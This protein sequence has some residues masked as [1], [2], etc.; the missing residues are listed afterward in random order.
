V[1]VIATATGEVRT[2]TAG[3]YPSALLPVGGDV[4]VANFGGGTVGVL[5][6]DG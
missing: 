6:P 4:W 5:P 3:L 2:V 1:S